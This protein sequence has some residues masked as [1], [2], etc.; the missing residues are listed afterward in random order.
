VFWAAGVEASPLGAR[1][2][3]PLDKAG[4]VNV[5]ADLS[6]PDRREI[7]VIGDLAHATDGGK[8]VPGVAQG[9]MQMGKH[10]AKMI[11][12]D[13]A[14]RPRFA[15]G[16]TDKGNLA[17]I[18]RARAVADMGRLRFSGLFAWLLWVF[19][20]ILYLIGFRN[21]IIVMTQWAWA[22]FTS[23]RG[24]RLITGQWQVRPRNGEGDDASSGTAAPGSSHSTMT[25]KPAPGA[26]S[27]VS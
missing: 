12:Q 19:I 9:A 23:Q 20:H 6:V 2:D 22:Y 18:G 3:A 17:T 5:E 4:R 26:T 21:R 25:D 11:A 14:G 27:G 1:L 10:A 8:P 7:F 16:Y 24:V 15:F 13:I